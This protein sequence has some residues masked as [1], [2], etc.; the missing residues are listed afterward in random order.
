[1]QFLSLE[2]YPR[3]FDDLDDAFPVETVSFGM[4]VEPAAVLKVHDVGA[5]EASYVPSAADFDRLDPRFRLPA[6]VLDQFEQ[7]RDFG[8][9]VFKLRG[10]E[11][12]RELEFHPMAFTFPS[13]L[14]DT[15]FFPIVHVHRGKVAWMADFDH[16]LYAQLSGPEE[17]RECWESTPLA[18]GAFMQVERCH[19]L[20]D[21]DRPCHR[22]RREGLEMNE[23]TELKA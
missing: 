10:K 2:D 11:G 21:P 18:A 15:I 22:F 20:V 8:F 5:Y 14:E 7:Y 6:G 23:D 3:F 16:E 19:G 4:P 13:R 17:K 9:A 1:M 12:Q